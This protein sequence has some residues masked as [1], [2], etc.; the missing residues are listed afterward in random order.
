MMTVKNLLPKFPS[1]KYVSVGDGD[2]RKNLLKLRKEL[3][4]ENNVELI[5]KSIEQEKLGLLEQSDVFVMPSVIY[6]K[7]V[8][9]FGITFIEAASYGKPS[10]GGIFG[11]E[12]DAILDGETGYLCDGNDLNALYETLLKTL[13]NDQF[14]KLGANALE[15]SKNF[16][17]DKIVK[18]Y[19]ELI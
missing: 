17:W 19:I 8:E 12:A 10:I 13:N 9:G 1:L 4:L 11:G 7:S 14:K 3:V 15:F 6:K 2:E 16:S 5:F 18:K